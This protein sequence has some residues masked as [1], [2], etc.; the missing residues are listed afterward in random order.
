MNDHFCNLSFHFSSLRH[1]IE[2]YKM[3]CIKGKKKKKN[4]KLIFFKKQYDDYWFVSE[5]LRL[6]R[7]C[8][9]GLRFACFLIA[10]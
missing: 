2:F 8:L 9:F 4:T 10:N 7:N 6:I 5:L 3:R 1:L